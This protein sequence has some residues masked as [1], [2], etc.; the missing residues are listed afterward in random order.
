MQSKTTQI[1]LGVVLAIFLM[2]GAFSG[3]V[4]VGWMVPIQGRVSN[5]A[6]VVSAPKVDSAVTPGVP[7]QAA[8]PVDAQT[9]FK[10]FWEAWDL[11]HQQYV[12]QPVDDVA[13]MRGAIK[14]M[15]DSLGD[16]H[17]SY[18]D[19]KIYTEATA[20][21]TGKTY[22]GIGAWV[23]ITGEYLKITSPMPNSPA[24]KAGIKTGDLIIAVDKED[25]TGIPGDVVLKRV[26]GPAGTNV[27]LTV[28]RKG[29]NQPFDITVTRAK[30]TVPQ[31]DG[32]MLDNQ[33]AYVRLYTFGDQTAP[34]LRRYL[35]DLLAKNP[36][37]LILDL[38]NNGGGWLDTAIT[39]VSEFIKSPNVVMY[40]QFG[41]GTRTTYKAKSGGLATDIPLVVL[42]NEG[43]ASASEITAGAIQDWGRGKLVGAKTYGKGSVQHISQLKE[44]GGAVR[45]TVARWLTPKERQIHKL[46]LTPDVVVPISDDDIKNDRDPQLDKAVEILT[47]GLP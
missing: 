7:T 35:K 13:L 40:E 17:S 28:V 23:D 14:G 41:D 6:P 5:P 25:M 2:G 34:E 8:K 11:V 9:L 32:R 33:I 44:D 19:P 18:M 46:G 15:I 16:Q 1:I 39:V 24:Q 22:E 10:P 27:V 12:D 31:V 36:K 30:I 26:L 3:G 43:T 37:G 38:R 29:S 45:I 47:S 42:V 4:V 20:D 21:L